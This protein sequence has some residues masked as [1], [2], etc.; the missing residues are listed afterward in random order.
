[1]SQTPEQN[2]DRLGI[3]L[4]EA[5]APIGFSLTH[6]QLILRDSSMPGIARLTLLVALLWFVLACPVHSQNLQLHYD[7]GHSIDPENNQSNYPS[8][9]FEFFKLVDSGT[10]FVKTQADFY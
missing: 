7:L 10:I 8:L 4:P 5:S 3:S 2:L 1:M 9:F 6:S